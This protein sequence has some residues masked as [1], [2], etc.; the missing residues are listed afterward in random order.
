MNFDYETIGEDA[1]AKSIYRHINSSSVPIEEGQA[2]F[3]INGQQSCQAFR[4]Q[5]PLTLAWAVT[6]NK[7]QGHTLPKIVIDM[8]PSKGKFSPGQAYVAFSQVCELSKLHIINYTC[9][10]IHVS[11]HAEAEIIRLRD[12]Q[13]PD[14]FKC[15]FSQTTSD[16]NLLHLNTGNIDR[17]LNDIQNDN[18][19]ISADIISF[20]ETHLCPDNNLTGSMLGLKED[21][22]IFRHDHSN[23]GGGVALL[24]KSTLNPVCITMNVSYE[25][26]GVQ[27]SNPVEMVIISV[28]RPHLC[29]C[30]NLLMKWHP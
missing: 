17:K 4:K 18:L 30:V 29:T 27:I 20:N 26:V 28:Y 21:Y 7:Y 22:T 23:S 25:V 14:M 11:P 16:L 24:G 10:L 5:F 13:Q 3:S 2:T 15:L 9:T 6:I 8:F 19:F 12:N 1:K